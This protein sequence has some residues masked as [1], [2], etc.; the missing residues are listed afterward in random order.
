MLF[1]SLSFTALATA[2]DRTTHSLEE[3]ISLKPG[4]SCLVS[5][6]LV[7]AVRPYLSSGIIDSRIHIEVIGD[8]S[9]ANVIRFTLRRDQ[10]VYA[11]RRFD[12]APSDC[13]QA[14][15]LIGLALAFAIDATWLVKNVAEKSEREA[16][17]GVEIRRFALGADALVST[18]VVPGIGLGTALRAEVGFF[19]WLDL[20][21]SMLG[22]YSGEQ[23]IE[24][25]GGAVDSLIAATRIDACAGLPI[26]SWVRMR[27]CM[28]FS[29]GVFAT[30]GN[31]LESSKVEARPW[32]ASA[33]GLDWLFTLFDGLKLVCAI[34]A[35]FPIQR[36]VIQVLGPDGEVAAARPLGSIGAAGR[37]GLL[38][39]FVE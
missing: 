25:S 34:D 17:S 11:T 5:E 13:E 18:G 19:D 23:S 27:G 28:G 20:R 33:S 38:F 15:A 10:T 35:V 22:V 3:A 31:G 21:A 39:F 37:I 8:P 9:R 36:R 12:N 2:Q 1:F 4:A 26:L 6:R 32:A 7:A 24:G 29:L 30:H 14:H 16:V